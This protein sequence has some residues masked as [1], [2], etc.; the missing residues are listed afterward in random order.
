MSSHAATT[1]DWMTLA[2]TVVATLALVMAAGVSSAAYVDVLDAPA[3]TSPLASQRILTGAAVAGAR[4]VTVGQRGH[5]LYSDDRG[6]TWSQAKVPVSV[7]LVAVHFPTARKGWAV[8]H[9]GVVLA[10]SDGGATW[11]KQLDGRTAAHV[12]VDH[13]GKQSGADAAALLEEARRF[14]E[15]GPDKPFLDVWFDNENVGYVVGVFNLVF[16]TDDGGKNWVPWFE[17]TDNP[18][19]YHLYAVRRIGDEL[20]MAGEQGIVLKL[21]AKALR[22]RAVPTPYE[23]TYFGI[24]GKPGSVLV[25]GLRGNAYRSTDGGSSWQKVD[26]RIPVGLTGGALTPDGRIV[27]VSQ[28]GHVLVS[29]DSGGTFALVTSDRPAPAAAV[30]T[31][32]ANSVL[33]AGPRGVQKSL[34]PAGT[35]TR[36]GAP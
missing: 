6:N 28:A 4:L 8:G 11:V 13:Y 2:M 32:G 18:K 31:L 17:R 5:I 34:L 27:L 21:D 33:I 30:V 15:E 24:T 20:Y 14:A 22:L 9:G 25:F 3:Q 29:S 19:R 16:R 23:G 12:M 35:Q 26:T 1:R 7:D 10:T 36:E